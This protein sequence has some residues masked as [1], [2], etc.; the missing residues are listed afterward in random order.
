MGRRPPAGRSPSDS[1][2]GAGEG[3]VGTELAVVRAGAFPLLFWFLLLVLFA[4]LCYFWSV[5]VPLVT[6][7]EKNVLKKVARKKK[8]YIKQKLNTYILQDNVVFSV[9]YICVMN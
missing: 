6:L 2:R 8:V 9:I 1:S 7:Q 5:L 3:R 4:F